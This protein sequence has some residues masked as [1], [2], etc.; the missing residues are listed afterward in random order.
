MNLRLGLQVRGGNADVVGMDVS[1]VASLATGLSQSKLASDVS[2]AVAKKT[3]DAQKAQGD[4][5]VALI[6][7]AGQ[8]GKSENGLGGSLDVKA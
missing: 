5:V 4:S 7:Q 3:L 8:V 1:S 6:D 2:L